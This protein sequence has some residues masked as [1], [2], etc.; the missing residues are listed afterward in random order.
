MPPSTAV[1][2]FPLIAALCYTFGA[3]V[4]KRSSDLGV[5]LWR[6]TFVANVVVAGLFSL[7]WLLGGEPV[8]TNLLWQPGVIALCLF[9]GQLSQ[10]LALEKGDVSVAVPVFGLK[11]VLVAFFTPFIIGDAVGVKLWLAALLS[12]LGITFLNRKDEGKSPKNIGIT[13]IAGGSGAVC[14]A[15]F[16]VLVQKWG[17]SWGVGRLLPMIFWMNAVL[18]IALIPM[19]KAP[20]RKVPSG[21]W[22]WL[23]MGSALLGTQSII[24]VST[25]A[26]HGKA[27][28]ANVVYASR[29]LLSVALVWLVGHW[30][31]NQ[32]QHLG[33]R[34]LR[35]R[36]IGAALM[37]AAIV[38]VVR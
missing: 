10:F 20:L 14:F 32:E 2:V 18:S 8:Q 12:V 1:I 5:G 17:P 6:T 11:V 23:L 27:T 13:L 26:I 9:G 3:L 22:P 24:F 15:M 36:T 31:A 29:G 28:A 34:V 4:L 19:F 21:A 7:L 16:D 25:V 33:A 38:L 35:W 37:L 30:F